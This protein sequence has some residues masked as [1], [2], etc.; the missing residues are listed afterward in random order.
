MEVRPDLKNELAMTLLT[1]W[2]ES[3]TGHLQPVKSYPDSAEYTFSD[4]NATKSYIPFPEKEIQKKTRSIKF[5]L[6]L[7]GNS[8][9]ELIFSQFCRG[10][11]DFDFVK[12][13]VTV[14]YSLQCRRFWWSF[15]SFAAILDSLQTAR[16]GAKMTECRRE[17]GR[18][19]KNNIFQKPDIDFY[20]I[21]HY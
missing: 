3:Y 16:I 18:G 14:F 9:S 20:E 5:Y 19:R 15:E 21:N 12:T 8:A 2:R 10:I 13:P 11:I 4:P 1:I 17:W 7:W 6:L